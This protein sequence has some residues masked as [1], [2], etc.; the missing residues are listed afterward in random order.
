MAWNEPGGKDKDPWGGGNRG[1]NNDGPPDL[2]EL[3]KKFQEKL[4]GLFGS[5]GGR[6]GSNNSAGI[7]SFLIPVIVIAGLYLAFQGVYRIDQQERGVVLRLGEYHRTLQPGLNWATPLLES[8]TTVNVTRLRQH[9]ASA[10]MLTK[11]E[12]IVS[13]SLSVQFNI[14]DA[15]SYALR[16]RD[17]EQSLKEA[18]DSALRHVVGSSKMDEVLTVG[19]EKIAQD[20]QLRLQEYL[21]NY[22]TGIMVTTVNVEETK[23]PREVEDAFDDVIKAREDQQRVMNEA[24][25]YANGVIPDARGKSQRQLEEANGYQAEVLSRAQGEAKRF[26]DLLV[27]YKKAPVVTRERL[28]I[29]AMQEV[30]GNS[31]K[32]MVDVKGGNNMMYLP[33]DKMVSQSSSGQSR[34]SVSPEVINQIEA[35]ILERFRQ[36]NA[37]NSSRGS[38]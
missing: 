37:N 2:D 4:N 18:T 8:V 13:V 9:S 34:T 16:V 19:R 1:N 35:R 26:S 12:N 7:G 21:D 30:M 11:D 28:Y 17:P 36:A 22:Q 27:E 31:S 25:A 23:P 38:R 20:V 5:G 33:L 24:Q 6:G 29:D 32:V 3:A 14:A 10:E 15:E